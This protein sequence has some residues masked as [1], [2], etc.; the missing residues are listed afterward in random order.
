[1]NALPQ[2]VEKGE[3]SSMRCWKNSP[4]PQPKEPV[5]L[6]RR[7]WGASGN[8]R[9]QFCVCK[10]RGGD[11]CLDNKTIESVAREALSPALSKTHSGFL[12]AMKG[13]GRVVLLPRHML[14]F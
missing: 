4:L 13:E 6:Q 7:W 12:R 3:T 9:Q 2:K 1:M 10:A 14:F 11:G 5:D 8:R